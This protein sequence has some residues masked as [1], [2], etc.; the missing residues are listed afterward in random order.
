MVRRQ[1]IKAADVA[2]LEHVARYHL[3]TATILS[4]ALNLD[5]GDA[6][7]ALQRLTEA[8]ALVST[9]LA[10]EGEAI[11]CYQLTPWAAQQL[12]YDA[13]FARPL[14]RE[15]RLE[16]FAIAQFCCGGDVF[17]QLYTKTEF[18]EKFRAIWH[19]GQPVRYYLEPSESD[20][21]RLAFLKVDTHGTGQWDRLI[22]A[23]TKFL[24]KRIDVPHANPAFRSQVA[25]FAELV[26]QGRFQ[27]SI[28]TALPE[29]QRAIEIELD[30]RQGAGL[31]V[32]PI[33][34]YVV[35]GLWEIMAL[36]WSVAFEADLD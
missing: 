8:G 33:C 27:F 2:I 24:H 29:K 1:R 12:G 13:A 11:V 14:A 16:C 26:R 28:L 21:P 20:R 7:T 18:I 32:P 17:R 30:R 25:A 15:A 23:C 9:L 19:R 36:R 34:V 6:G 35:P 10:P 5:E 22:D 4:S 3:T 31:S